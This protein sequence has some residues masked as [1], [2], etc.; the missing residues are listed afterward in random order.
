MTLLKMIQAQKAH[1]WSIRARVG[2]LEE[3]K[4]WE[5]IQ[6]FFWKLKN[7]PNREPL[8]LEVMLSRQ[9]S[10]EAHNNS[11][12]KLAAIKRETAKLQVVWREYKTICLV[13]VT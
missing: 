6:I 11:I 9:E 12:T 7:Q 8:L 4:E 3:S 10:G 2:N 5:G 1:H 13:G